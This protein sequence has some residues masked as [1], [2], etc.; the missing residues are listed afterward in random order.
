MGDELSQGKRCPD[1]GVPESGVPWTSQASGKESPRPLGKVAP[2]G[3]P[4]PWD[5]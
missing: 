2:E 1:L 3:R 4:E 5:L